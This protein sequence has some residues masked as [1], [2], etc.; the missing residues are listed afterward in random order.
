MMR[1]G[2]SWEMWHS[3]VQPGTY[4][5]SG[6]RATVRQAPSSAPRIGGETRTPGRVRRVEY[7]CAAGEACPEVTLHRRSAPPA[8]EQGRSLPLRKLAGRVTSLISAPCDSFRFSRLAS[9]AARRL[10]WPTPSGPHPARPL[11]PFPLRRHPFF[12]SFANISKNATGHFPPSLFIASTLVVLALSAGV[13][14]VGMVPV[15]VFLSTAQG[16]PC[17]CVM[18]TPGE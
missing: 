9:S 7:L 16:T 11:L 15:F 3:M 14:S 1:C 12:D 5:I 18:V 2:P 10:F 6:N 4:G 13:M 17:S 8:S